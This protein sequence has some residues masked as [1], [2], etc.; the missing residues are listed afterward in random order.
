MEFK[1]VLRARRSVRSFQPQEVGRDQ[2]QE[3]I[4]A[5]C[6][7][8]SPLHLQPWEF[9]TITDPE[10]KAR[11]K[12]VAGEA[13]EKVVQGGGPGWAA[14]YSLD[15]LTQ[16]PVL[17][18]VLYAPKKGGLG[19]FFNQPHGALCAAAAG[20]QN[21]MLAAAEMGLGSL[22][23]TFFDP[24]GMKAALKVPEHLDLAGI[25]PLGVPA[26]EVKAPPRKPPKVFDQTYEG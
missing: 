2:I 3:L 4:E 11:V 1:D 16:A 5:C 25:I 12:A 21:L 22:W 9:I 7:A 24:D 6:W 17:L 20:I 19:S 10:V 15:F 13:L 14:K 8:P 23:F 18:A 26:G